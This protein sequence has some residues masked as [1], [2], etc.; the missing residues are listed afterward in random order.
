MCLLNKRR[1]LTFF[2]T[3]GCHIIIIGGGSKVPFNLGAFHVQAAANFFFYNSICV[4]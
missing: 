4:V 2:H 1:Y 3:T